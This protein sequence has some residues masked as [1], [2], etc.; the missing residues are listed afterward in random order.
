[1]VNLNTDTI[2]EDTVSVEPTFADEKEQGDGVLSKVV[3]KAKQLKDVV[4]DETKTLA[5]EIKDE[6][7]EST[8]RLNAK[9]R[10][11]SPVSNSI[12]YY[13]IVGLGLY[14]VIKKL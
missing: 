2:N 13:A 14:W 9:Q 8:E 6:F 1:M 11:F 12:I 7:R 10:V 4:V 5:P 3:D